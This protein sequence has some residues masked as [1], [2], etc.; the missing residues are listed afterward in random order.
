MKQTILKLVEAI[1]RLDETLKQIR[2]KPAR[3]KARMFQPPSVDEVAAYI[4]AHGYSF[5][6]EEFWNF[7]E[8]K[9]WRIGAHIMKSWTSACATWQKRRKREAA[10]EAARQAHIDAKM[11]ERE[12][13]RREMLSGAGRRDAEAAEAARQAKQARF[14]HEFQDFIRS[15]HE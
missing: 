13:A 14:Y 9:G 1:D 12:S 2:H 6:A 10:I 3:G 7:Y 4:A 5:D 11:D 15:E 8:S